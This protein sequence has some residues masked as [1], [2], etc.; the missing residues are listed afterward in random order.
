MRPGCVVVLDIGKT[1]SKLTIW[2]PDKQ[3]IERRSHR[4]ARTVSDSYPTLDVI[5]PGGCAAPPR[6]R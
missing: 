1:L 3:L 2:S 5:G 4:N 6:R